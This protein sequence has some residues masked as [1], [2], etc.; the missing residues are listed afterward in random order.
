[1]MAQTANASAACAFVQ[2]YPGESAQPRMVRAAL[3]P[4]LEGCPCADD[5]VLVTSEL[6]ANAVVHSK[7]AVPGGRFT[8]RAEVRPGDYVWIEVEDEG[9]P[10]TRRGGSDGRPHGLNLV[11]MLAGPANWGIDGNAEHGHIVWAR[12]SWRPR[13]LR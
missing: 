3:A 9:G 12:L 5:A 10:W 7:S 2:S 8:V 11:D 6:A 1:M 4:L 13:R